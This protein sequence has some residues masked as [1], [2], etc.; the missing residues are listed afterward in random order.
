VREVITRCELEATAGHDPG[1]LYWGRSYARNGMR[2]TVR[3][4]REREPI[5]AVG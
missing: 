1:L 2:V 4:A 5:S 3:A